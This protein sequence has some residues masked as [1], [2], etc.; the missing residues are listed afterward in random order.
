MT[1]KNKYLELDP[2]IAKP[3]RYHAWRLKRSKYLAHHD[4]E[5]IEQDLLYELYSCLSQYNEKKGSF[6]SFANK[7]ISRRSNN[8]IYRQLS[9]K[10]G[11]KV[12]TASL[13]QENA[14]GYTL[15]D[16]VPDNNWVEQD[17][18]VQIDVN[19]YVSK[20]PKDWQ[21]LCQ[22]LKLF[23]VTEI[24]KMSGR[25]RAT[26]YRDLELIRPLL[27]PLLVYLNK[28]EQNYPNP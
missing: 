17:L 22:Q 6:Q 1:S 8:L 12:H 10:R 20:L 2:A 28:S 9:A 15:L 26:I 24:A 23:T 13:N 11:A 7:V 25:S 21:L 4:I 3:I 5:D 16:S 14:K 19:N 27:T 18:E